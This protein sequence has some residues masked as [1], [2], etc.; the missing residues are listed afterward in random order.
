M[1]VRYRGGKVSRMVDTC[2][3]G[4]F[5][6]RRTFLNLTVVGLPFLNLA[7]CGKAVC[8]SHWISCSV[9][10][11][12][13]PSTWKYNQHKQVSKKYS[14]VT[15]FKGIAQAQHIGSSLMLRLGQGLQQL[16][17]Q[18]QPQGS[19]DLEDLQRTVSETL[20][21]RLT[22]IWSIFFNKTRWKRF[23][24]L[25][26]ELVSEEECVRKSHSKQKQKHQ[27]HSKQKQNLQQLVF[28]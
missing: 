21:W 24:S 16:L 9:M 7:A 20:I 15:S 8:D 6:K 19:R 28:S 11:G 23:S 18:V 17:P 5:T 4:R 2:W 14:E 13:P 22:K 26:S 3:R 27:N 10:K 1:W 12:F 25:T